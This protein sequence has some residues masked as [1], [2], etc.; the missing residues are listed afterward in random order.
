MP[1]GRRGRAGPQFHGP[2][3][4]WTQMLKSIDT[5]VDKFERQM[6]SGLG[7]TTRSGTAARSATSSATRKSPARGKAKTKR[8]ASQS[9]PFGR[10]TKLARGQRKPRATAMTT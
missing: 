7:A 3:S 6:E 9:G 10:T 8:A 1:T 5:A 4:A 2:K